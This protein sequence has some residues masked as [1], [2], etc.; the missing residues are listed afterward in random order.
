MIKP[1]SQAGATVTFTS[2]VILPGPL[3]NQG[4]TILPNSR[5][6]ENR[7]ASITVEQD[8]KIRKESLG[9]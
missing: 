2:R 7:N 5:L 3:P 1:G 9:E 4:L 6:S 8:D